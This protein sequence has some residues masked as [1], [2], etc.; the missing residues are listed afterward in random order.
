[1]KKKYTGKTKEEALTN[2]A[3]DLNVD[4][5]EIKY[6]VTNEI[7]GLFKK[8]V[9]IECYTIDMVLEYAQSYI[10]KIIN[11]L[12]FEIEIAAFY[13]DGRIYLNINTSNNSILIGKNGI[14]LRALNLVVRNS[15]NNVYNEKIQLNLDINGY[16]EN[17]YKKVTAMAKRFAKSVLRTKTTYK[18]DP[19]PAD[20][21]RVIHQ[22]ISE[23]ENLATESIGEGKNRYITIKYKN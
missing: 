10:K 20:E 19:L 7:N 22:V 9:D 5:S 23:Y 2:A 6:Q 12:D 1:M 17:R 13:Q 14:I 15:I 4:I 3:N 11:D 21:R 8:R 16:K 18:L